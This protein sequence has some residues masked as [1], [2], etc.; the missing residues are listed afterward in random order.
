M[1][2]RRRSLTKAEQ[3]A[4]ARGLLNLI[5]GQD[6][7]LGAQRVA[8]YRKHDGEIDPQPLLEHSL[9]LGK[10]CYLPVVSKDVRQKQLTF[11][12]VDGDTV[13]TRNRWGI[14]E[15]PLS[16]V[17]SAERLELVFIPLTGFGG[18]GQR[19]GMGMGFYDETFAFRQ[20]DIA[21]QPC[22]VGL[23]YECQRLD[24]FPESLQEEWDVVLD[25]VATPEKIYRP[26]AA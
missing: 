9:S 12:A 11:A 2:D 18:E 10:A 17:L 19:L 26:D 1:R 6:F 25:A 14:D 23:A 7:Y 22:L 4:A 24:P 20:S 3:K 5:A 15:P 16:G 8:Y 21:R 13:L